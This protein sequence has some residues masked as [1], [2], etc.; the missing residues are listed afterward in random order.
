MEDTNEKDNNINNKKK[1]SE[2]LAPESYAKHIKLLGK[3][4]SGVLFPMV[5]YFVPSLDILS[6]YFPPG[7]NFSLFVSIK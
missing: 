1:L 5:L 6:H 2:K 3:E 7:I 4:K